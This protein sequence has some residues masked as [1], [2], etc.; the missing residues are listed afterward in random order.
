M[1][2]IFFADFLDLRRLLENLLDLSR[3]FFQ[4]FVGLLGHEQREEIQNRNLRGKSLGRANAHFG[5]RF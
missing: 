4:F 5:A 3:N 2:N 1:L